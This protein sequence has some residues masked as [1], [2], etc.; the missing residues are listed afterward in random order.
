[1][2]EN[3]TGGQGEMPMDTTPGLGRQVPW[4]R[5]PAIKSLINGID[6]WRWRESNYYRLLS[7]RKLLVLLDAPCTVLAGFAGVTHVIHTRNFMKL[8]FTTS[9][10]NRGAAAVH[11]AHARLS[12]ALAASK[13]R[14]SIFTEQVP[15]S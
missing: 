10:V 9:N 14:I 2:T 7:H 13:V 5:H 12:G 1:M 6:W 4:S 3:V 11:P 8:D 15:L